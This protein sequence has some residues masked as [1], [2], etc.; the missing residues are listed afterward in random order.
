MSDPENLQGEYA[1]VASRLVAFLIDSVVIGTSTVVAAWAS[2]VLLDYLKID[3]TDCPEIDSLA[4]ID[5][6]NA[7]LLL[8]AGLAA[9]FPSLYTLFFWSTTGQTPG[10]A[11]LGVR[12]VRLDGEPMSLFVA[13][14]RLVGYTLSLATLGIG[15]AVMLADDRRQG[16]ADKLAGTCVVY[17]WKARRGGERR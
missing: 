8:G 1:G 12:V 6:C 15:F 5:P 10:K 3:V 13:I 4:M 2:V 16:W 11:A 14:R 7:L 17:S 9:S